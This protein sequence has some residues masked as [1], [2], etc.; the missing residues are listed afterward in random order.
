MGKLNRTLIKGVSNMKSKVHRASF[1]L[2]KEYVKLLEM[3][4]AG[5]HRSNTAQLRHMIVKYAESVG[6]NADDV[7][8]KSRPAPSAI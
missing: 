6:V 7:L 1:S 3:L 2:E 8:T 5:E 4:A